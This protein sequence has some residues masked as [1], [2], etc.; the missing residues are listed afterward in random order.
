ME[1]EKQ[2]PFFLKLKRLEIKIISE[3]KVQHSKNLQKRLY[4]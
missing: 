1:D 2:Y 3:G 4:G